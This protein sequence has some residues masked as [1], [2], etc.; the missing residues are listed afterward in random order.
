[1][2]KAIVFVAFGTA[3]EEDFKKYLLP[4]KEDAE[5]KYGREFDYYFA[6]TSE[7]ILKKFNN[8][9]KS[10]EDTLNS[11]KQNEYEEVYIVPLYFSRGLEYS[12]VEKILNFY[13]YSFKKLKYLKPIFEENEDI[14]DD[15]FKISKNILFICHGSRNFNES[16]DKKFIE[17]KILYSG[18]KHYVSSTNEK[19]NIDELIKDIKEDGIESILIIPILLTKGYHFTKDIILDNDESFFSK[20]KKNNIK[21]K[22]LDKVLGEDESFRKLMMKNIDSIIKEKSKGNL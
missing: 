10:Y 13:K 16:L 4:F 19:D 15:Y 1:M 2:K 9:I 12:K 6:V 5:K 7:R 20:L 14:L 22:V 21:A 17:D 11:L 18:K 8:K 3:K